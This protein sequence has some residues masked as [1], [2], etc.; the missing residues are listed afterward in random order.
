M[1][2]KRGTVFVSLNGEFG[3]TQEGE[4]NTGPNALGVVLDV[5]PEQECKYSFLI[6]GTGVTGCLTDEEMHGPDY[7]ILNGD[8][9]DY[10]DA[11][12][13]FLRDPEENEFHALGRKLMKLGEA[14]SNVDSTL[15]D[16]VPLAHD[17]G[18]S[19]QFRLTNN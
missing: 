16:V 13:G 9:S 14:M 11:M 12:S 15:S 10:L 1:E 3:D 4:V 2:I 18:L 7:E 6:V 5:L 8:M 19:L 17:A